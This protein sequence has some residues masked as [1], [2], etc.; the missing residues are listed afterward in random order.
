[1]P[2][3][4]L[5]VRFTLGTDICIYSNILFSS[6]YTSSQIWMPY[7]G[8]DDSPGGS[9]CKHLIKVITHATEVI[10]TNKTA[11]LIKLIYYYLTYKNCYKIALKRNSRRH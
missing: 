6:G 2:L 1:M 5:K 7:C 11:W 8:E 3:I 4:F 10:P 9:G